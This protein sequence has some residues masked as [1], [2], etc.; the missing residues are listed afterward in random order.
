MS[1]ATARCSGDGKGVPIG[2]G[3]SSSASCL[4]VNTASTPSIASAALVS[5]DLMRPCATSL[6]LKAMCCS[7]AIFTSST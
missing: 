5:I 3:L 6:R 4:P 2:I 1:T 7:P